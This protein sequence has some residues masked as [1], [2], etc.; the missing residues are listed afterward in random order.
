MTL[1]VDMKE[2]SAACKVYTHYYSDAKSFKELHI[3]IPVPHSDVLLE[4]QSSIQLELTFVPIRLPPISIEAFSIN[5]RPVLGFTALLDKRKLLFVLN[6]N[7]HKFI[8]LS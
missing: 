7:R 3:S 4:L 5:A 2:N 6:K 8:L 1:I